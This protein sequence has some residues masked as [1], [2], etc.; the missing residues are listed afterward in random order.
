MRVVYLACY[1]P[2]AMKGVIG[3]SDRKAAVEAMLASVG[4]KLV[5]FMFA[6]GEF[7]AV[8]T[9]DLPDRNAA[10]AGVMGVLASGGVSRLTMLEEIDMAAVLP[11]AQKAATV[12]I[13]AG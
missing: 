8:V 13:P 4:G 7:D 10:V 12:F 3:G 2:N 9:V 11:L 6:R 1:T 5:S